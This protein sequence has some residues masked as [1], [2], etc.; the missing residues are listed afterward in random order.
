MKTQ[1]ILFA[2]IGLALFSSSLMATGGE[3]K[4]T[5]SVLSIHHQLSQKMTC[6]EFIH[7]QGVPVGITIQFHVENDFTVI[8]EDIDCNDAWLKQHVQKEM[9]KLKL[10]VDRENI[11][12]SFAFKVVYR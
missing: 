10:L 5:T 12:K 2:F 8:V 9:N 3:V 1:K 7:V 4:E 6:P 11:G